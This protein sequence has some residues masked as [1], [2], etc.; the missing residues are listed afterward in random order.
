M[1][2]QCSPKFSFPHLPDLSKGITVVINEGQPDLAATFHIPESLLKES[3]DFFRA[4]CRNEWT[5][6]TSRVIKLPDVELEIFSSYLFWIYRRRL[7]IRNEWD[8][9]DDDCEEHAHL[10]QTRLTK[11]WILADRLADMKFRNATIDEMVAA[12]GRLGDDSNFVLFTPDMTNVVWSA[13]TPGRSLRRL[14]LDFYI[15]NVWA[16]YVEEN[17]DDLHPEFVKEL[18]LAA[19]NKVDLQDSAF[20][21]P[22]DRVSKEPCYYHD[23]DD[24]VREGGCGCVE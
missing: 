6:A 18:M 13:K 17:M 4:A 9:R 22:F 2:A 3:S 12:T 19:L 16:E 8:P 21:T 7:P 24:E 23:H 1:Q 5:E 15:G 14:L 11:L 10:V 20:L